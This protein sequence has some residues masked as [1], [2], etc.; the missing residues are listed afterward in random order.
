MGEISGVD[1]PPCHSW[2]PLAVGGGPTSE[3][4][5]KHQQHSGKL[6]EDEPWQSR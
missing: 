3:Q 2:Y 5:Y 4:V 1:L 6:G